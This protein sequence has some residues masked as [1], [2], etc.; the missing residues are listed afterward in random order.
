M[1]EKNKRF[2]VVFDVTGWQVVDTHS[3]CQVQ[4]RGLKSME[5][6]HLAVKEIEEEIESDMAERITAQL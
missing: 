2:L 3:N 1:T 4:V 6:G 5:D